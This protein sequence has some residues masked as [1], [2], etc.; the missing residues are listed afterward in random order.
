M[1]VITANLINLGLNL[2]FIKVFSWGIQ[3]SSLATTIGYIVGIGVASTHFLKDDRMLHFVKPTLT[4]GVGILLISG[5]P[6]ALASVL[7][8]VRALFVNNIIL[9]SLG[10]AGMTILAVSSNI[11]MISSMFISSTV[12]SIQPVDSVLYGAQDYKGVRMTIRTAVKTLSISLVCVMIVI[13]LFPQFFASLFGLSDPTLLARAGTAIRIFAIT[14]P[15]FGLN[16]LIMVIFQLSKRNHFSIMVSCAQALMVIPFILWATSVQNE[17]FT[18]FSFVIAQVL[19]SVLIL[20]ISAWVRRKQPQLSP[21]TLIDAPAEDE[22]ILDFSVQGNVTQMEE[23]MGSMHQFL[24]PKEFSVRCKNAIEICGEE[25]VLNIMQHSYLN[26]KAHYIDIRLR[27]Q[28]DKALLSVSDDG[29]P[30][31]PIKYD[32]SGIGLLLVKKLCSEIKYS[33]SLNQNVVNA[34]FDCVISNG[35]IEK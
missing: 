30:F 29:I 9:N 13:M 25:L 15:V 34:M 12:V 7:T 4:K 28:A 26:K 6:I 19:V 22:A 32:S 18:W 35:S 27:L 14:L 24:Q 1:A 16:Y 20:I 31:D 8:T 21:I 10:V 3:S 5:L 33:R 11:L 17:I 23:F 2:L